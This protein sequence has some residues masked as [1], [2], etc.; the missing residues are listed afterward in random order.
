MWALP[1]FG[2]RKPIPIAQTPSL[3]CCGRFS[4]DRRW[5]SYASWETGR[6][7][8]YV[9]AFP[10]TTGRIR[11]STDGGGGPSWSAD[12][13]ELFYATYRGETLS[14]T[15]TPDGQSLRFG[16]PRLLFRQFAVPSP[17]G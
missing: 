1:L 5:V 10:G 16:R 8:V 12:G 11:V 4:P 2:D 9:Q 6:P 3:E 7:E 15:V 17:D 14:V 13:H